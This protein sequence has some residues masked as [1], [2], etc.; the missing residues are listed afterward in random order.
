METIFMDTEKSKKNAPQKFC[1]K[2]L[3]RLYLKSED[4]HVAL[5]SSLLV[6]LFI[7][8]GKI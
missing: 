2:L 8:C 3:Q 6:S 1:L 5:Q 4:K 7:T